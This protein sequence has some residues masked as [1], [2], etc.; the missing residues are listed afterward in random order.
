MWTRI[1]LIIAMISKQEVKKN[2]RNRNQNH[3]AEKPD[4]K[5]KEQLLSPKLSRQRNVV[6]RLA[7]GLAMILFGVFIAVLLSIDPS[8][9]R[10]ITF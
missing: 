10:S 6:L 9:N 7:A 5:E 4:R 1:R 8:M 2:M 3:E